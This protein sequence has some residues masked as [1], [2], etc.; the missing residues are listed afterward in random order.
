MRTPARR[1]FDSAIAVFCRPAAAAPFFRRVVPTTSGSSSSTSWNA[2]AT[3]AR[4][5]ADFGL[6][7]AFEGECP[8]SG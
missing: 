2:A 8:A 7:R 1:A 6:Y 4:P 5:F 3:F